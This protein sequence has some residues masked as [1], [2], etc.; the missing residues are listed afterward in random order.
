MFV[1]ASKI[2]DI[3][4]DLRNDPY[5][6]GKSLAYQPGIIQERVLQMFDGFIKELSF[7]D[8]VSGYV[9]EN[10]DTA[11]RARSIEMLL[12]DNDLIG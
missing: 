8:K 5:Q 6:L 1:S 4:A 9:N 3:L 10:F 2:S 7:Q 11:V 12:T